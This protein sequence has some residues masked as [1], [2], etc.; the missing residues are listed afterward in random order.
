MLFM[1]MILTVCDTC[2]R[3]GWDAERDPLTD[4]EKLADL[5]ERVSADDENIKTRRHS[6]LMGCDFG[7]NISLQAEDKII[8]SLGMFAPELESAE[9]IVE[10]AQ[11]YDASETGQVPYKTWPAG[12]KGHFRARIPRPGT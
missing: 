6:C 9:A 2:K 11:K 1:A 12:V 10:F 3:E 5:V 8:Y 7:C 4:G